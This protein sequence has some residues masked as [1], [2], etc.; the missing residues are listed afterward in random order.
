[1]SVQLLQSPGLPQSLPLTVTVNN[2]V[3]ENTVIPPLVETPVIKLPTEAV[4]TSGD[5][6]ET[7]VTTP[8]PKSVIVAKQLDITPAKYLSKININKA[9]VLRN[10]L[11]QNIPLVDAI[12]AKLSAEENPELSVRYGEAISPAIEA[13]IEVRNFYTLAKYAIKHAKDSS[14]AEIIDQPVAY[15][16]ESLQELLSKH[17]QMDGALTTPMVV[18]KLIDLLYGGSLA[19][20]DTIV[21]HLQKENPNLTAVGELTQ[22]TGKS[23]ESVKGWFKNLGKQKSEDEKHKKAA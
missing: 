9:E 7:T 2:I 14:I 3:P 1:M 23:L 10:E 5:T 21:G 19:P 13:E 11:S 18:I 4:A 12:I 22:K 15:A 8:E 6:F 17:Q 20:L 16:P